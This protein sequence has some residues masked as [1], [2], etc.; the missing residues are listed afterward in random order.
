MCLHMKKNK[1]QFCEMTSV[2]ADKSPALIATEVVTPLKTES[3]GVTGNAVGRVTA[4]KGTL[5]PFCRQE[6]KI[7]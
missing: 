3:P 4:G 2:S 6:L 1:S 7:G 5:S